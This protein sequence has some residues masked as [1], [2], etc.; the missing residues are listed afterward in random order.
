MFSLT[1]GYFAL[2][3]AVVFFTSSGQAVCDSAISQTVTVPVRSAGLV[4][5]DELP[6]SLSD[7]QAATPTN[8]VATPIAAMSL[9]F[10]PPSSRM[11]PETPP[12][13]RIDGSRR[14]RTLAS[15]SWVW[16][17]SVIGLDQYP[18]LGLDL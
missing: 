8:M 6:L 10:T 2:K 4:V 7:P 14:T 3:A 1:L 16:D 17:W 15:C 12:T 11:M 9:R 5:A 13:A 18:E